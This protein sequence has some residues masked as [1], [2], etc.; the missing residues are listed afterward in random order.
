[1]WGGDEDAF[2]A[3]YNSDGN[4]QW[5]RQMGTSGTDYSFSVAVDNAGNAFISGSTEGD[6]GGVNGGYWDAFLTK[7]DADGNVV[8]TR[9]LG[10]PSLDFSSSV[11]VDGGG[12][13]FIIGDTEGDLSGVNAGERDVFLAKYDSTGNLLWTQQLGTSSGES[14]RCVDVDG[15]GNVYITGATAGSLGGTFAGG[16]S[17]AFL[18]KYEVPEPACFSLLAMGGLAFLRRRHK[19]RGAG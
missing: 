6:L 2:L 3:K 5:T 1:M 16:Y 7:Y 8:W 19:A 4:L 12:D 11:A 18:V 9:Q 13:V 17:D 10:S 15:T 14:T